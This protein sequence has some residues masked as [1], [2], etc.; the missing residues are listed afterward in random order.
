MNF[1][2]VGNYEMGY[3]VYRIS[4]LERFHRECLENLEGDWRNILPHSIP[5]NQ[6]PP[7]P[8]Q[9]FLL[10]QAP[11]KNPISEPEML[12]SSD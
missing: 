3:T 11:P 1:W 9:H 12:F 2:D 7:V 8:A 4:Q 10:V 6:I 5:A